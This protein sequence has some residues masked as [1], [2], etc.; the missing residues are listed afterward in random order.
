MNAEDPKQDKLTLMMLSAIDSGPGIS[1]RR[2][3]GHMGVALGLANSYIKRCVKKGFIKINEAPANRYLYY[4]TPKGFK[5]KSRLTA[6]FL[7]SSLNFY[8]SAAESCERVFVNCAMDGVSHII[9]CGD[10]ELAEI[11]FLKS[12]ESGISVDGLFDPSG[13]RSRF[14][15]QTVWHDINNLPSASCVIT[16]LAGVDSLKKDL[17]K[18]RSDIVYVPDILDLKNVS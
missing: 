1:Q 3:A 10:S 2:L 6:R 18:N 14:F 16:A 13:E 17:E 9:L 8:R 4:L 7:S 15:S 12:L 5:E 11:A